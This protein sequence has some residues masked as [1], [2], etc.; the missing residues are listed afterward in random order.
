L[1]QHGQ[2]SVIITGNQTFKFV[3]SR[4][5]LYGGEASI[6]IHP[7]PLDWLHFENAISV[8]YGINRGANSVTLADNAKDLPFIPPL[9]THSEL[10]A[11]IQKKYKY[12]SSIYAQ[13]EMDYYATQYRA[14]LADNTETVTPGYTLFN[15]GFGMDLTNLKGKIIC[16]L[17]I[18]G[19]NITDV[20]YQSHLSRLKYFEPYPVNWS[21]HSGIYNMGRNIGFKM[22]FPL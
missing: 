8:I 17:H 3:Q 20:A 16:N 15:A 9:H 7:H 6:D 19:N 5:Q 13:V 10:K 14:Y 12:A 21:G 18:S 2:D 1:N 4:A 11:E 22:T